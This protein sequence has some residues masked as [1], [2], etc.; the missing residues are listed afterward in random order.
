MRVR[1]NCTATNRDQ[2][3]GNRRDQRNV[4]ELGMRR[5]CQ[6]SVKWCPKENAGK[7][8]GQQEY[9]GP[10]AKTGKFGGSNPS[11]S[12]LLGIVDAERTGFRSDA[13]LI[14]EL[15]VHCQSRGSIGREGFEYLCLPAGHSQLARTVGEAYPV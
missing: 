1:K 15:R 3:C 12:S 14:A 5:K 13:A 2:K 4:G 10:V 7:R 9:V 8:Q 11:R 6:Y